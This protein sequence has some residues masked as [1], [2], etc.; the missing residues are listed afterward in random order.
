V[1][2]NIEIPNFDKANIIISIA[3]ANKNITAIA[4][5]NFFIA[6]YGAFG[7]D[8]VIVVVL[9]VVVSDMSQTPSKLL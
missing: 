1:K 7:E 6:S 2:E 8:A 4:T 5:R 3:Y 9:V